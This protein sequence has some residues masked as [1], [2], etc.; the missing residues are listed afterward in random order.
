MR[1]VNSNYRRTFIKY[2][3]TEKARRRAR[4]FVLHILTYPYQSQVNTYGLLVEILDALISSKLSPIT[5]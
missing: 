2:L 3:R 4:N 5:L 1:D